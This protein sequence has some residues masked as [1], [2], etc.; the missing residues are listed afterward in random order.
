M[1]QIMKAFTGLFVVMF[2]MVTATGLL[3]AFF[4]TMHAQN[5]HA[6]VIDEMENSNYARSVLEGCFLAV[7]EAGYEM[8]L[9]LYTEYDGFIKCESKETL[10]VITEDIV[11]A[12]VTLKYPFQI[13]FFQVDVKQELFGYAR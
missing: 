3:G 5:L 11:M 8:E 12:E 2:M 10:P 9:T 4:Q 7:E 6:A 1:S 13:G